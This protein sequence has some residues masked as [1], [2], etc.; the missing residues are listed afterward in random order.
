MF[1][2]LFKCL[3]ILANFK[4]LKTLVSIRPV[5]QLYV[6][7]NV[8]IFCD[9]IDE[10][11]TIIW[12]R[13]PYNDPTN[14][15]RLL[16]MNIPDR[17]KIERDD[18]NSTYTVSTLSISAIVQEDFSTF[19]CSSI[20]QDTIDLIEAPP[21]TTTSTTTTSTT[22]D[23][24]T[25]TPD[26]STLCF[27]GNFNHVL[28]AL[29]LISKF[30]L[31][32]VLIAFTKLLQPNSTTDVLVTFGCIVGSIG[33]LIIKVI[34][35]INVAQYPANEYLSPIVIVPSSIV[36]FIIL[37]GGI[38]YYIIR[39]Y[40]KKGK[41][42]RIPEI[43]ISSI[44]A[45]CQLLLLLVILCSVVYCTG[46]SAFSQIGTNY[47]VVSNICAGLIVASCFIIIIYFFWVFR[48]RLTTMEIMPDEMK[49]KSLPNLRTPEPF[50]EKNEKI[51]ENIVTISQ[52]TERKPSLSV[53]DEMPNLSNSRKN[54]KLD[55]KDFMNSNRS[56]PAIKSF[57][58]ES[59][60][61]DL[62]PSPKIATS[63][64]NNQAR[65]SRDNVIDDFLIPTFD[66]VASRVGY[67]NAEEPRSSFA[68]IIRKNSVVNVMK[69][70]P[71]KEFEDSTVK[72]SEENNSEEAEKS[73]KKKKKSLKKKEIDESL[74]KEE[75]EQQLDGK[76]QAIM[77]SAQFDCIQ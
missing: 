57:V 56:N 26:P 55:L 15:T 70:S 18:V 11:I 5:P 35:W 22:P 31:A 17:Y 29:L 43:V 75:N 16:G 9:L 64:F 24:T 69:Q 53:R 14:S 48:D 72:K 62:L 49:K 3:I 51:P 76:N 27:N 68:N 61:N 8:T 67:G 38:F 74:S 59:K 50:S 25:T 58:S 66:P 33:F 60:Q 40:L 23:P 39:T 46:R 71:H 7:N 37:W 28:F 42:I 45:F 36:A 47:S 6:G 20:N 63:L 32:I 54:S 52:T 10:D 65:K 12:Q 19:D 13:Y 4:N 77:N 34:F 2:L 44:I 21:T 73:P 41:Y 1:F 30:T